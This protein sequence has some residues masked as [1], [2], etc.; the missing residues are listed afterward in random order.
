MD[1]LI[2]L[3]IIALA[4][5]I[6]ISKGIKIVPQSETEVIERLGRYDRTLESGLNIILPFIDKPREISTRITHQSPN[7]K[8]YAII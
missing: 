1:S 5:V 2:I 3:G 8:I 6:F 4:V 7:G